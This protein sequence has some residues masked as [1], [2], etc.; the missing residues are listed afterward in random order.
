MNNGT[1]HKSFRDECIHPYTHVYNSPVESLTTDMQYIHTHSHTNMIHTRTRAAHTHKH[2]HSYTHA[3]AHM[4]TLE[5]ILIGEKI[6]R[7]LVP[8]GGWCGV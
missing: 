5:C 1:G 2:T 4:H 3:H 6:E 7:I 8:Q